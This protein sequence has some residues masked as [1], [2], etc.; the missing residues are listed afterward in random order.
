MI[1][2][3]YV[4]VK[5][6]SR[7]FDYYKSLIPN[8]KNNKVYKVLVNDIFSGS[9]TKI[10]VSCDVCNSNYEKPY[11]QYK[12]SFDKYNMY[13]CSPKCAQL[14]NKITNLEKYG[15]INVFQSDIIKNK[16]IETNLLK[17]GVSYPSQSSHIRSKIINTL[18]SN[19]GVSN[20]IYSEYIINKINNTN[21]LKYGNIIYNCSNIAK[22]LRIKNNRQIPDCDRSEFEKYQ[23]KVRYLTNKVKSILYE[24]WNG[25]DYYDNEFIRNN[26]NYKFYNKNY[27]TIDHK[28][29]IYYGFM[30][31]INPEIIGNLE[32]LCITKRGI[33][34]KKNNKNEV[35]FIN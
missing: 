26:V 2:Q 28:I 9:H 27:P 12:S 19:Y 30:N 23:I 34:S 4:D 33:N 18:R 8:I 17:Y 22:D 13:C 10:L 35:F 21:L 5:I 32:N 11:R 31:N 7:N 3:E 29:S 24:N 15:V 25:F 1:L 16:I 6:N 14:K 20:P